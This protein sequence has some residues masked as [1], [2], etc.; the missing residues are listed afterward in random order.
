MHIKQMCKS[1]LLS[2]GIGV[3]YFGGLLLQVIFISHTVIIY[4]GITIYRY[5]G[6][7]LFYS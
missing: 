5:G 3:L 7:E 2:R 1:R 6:E 4:S